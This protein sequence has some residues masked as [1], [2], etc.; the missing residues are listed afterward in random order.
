MTSIYQRMLGPEFGRLHPEI[1][2][3]FGFC[4][5]DRIASIGRGVMDR[6]WYGRAFTKPFLSL[7]AWR[8]IMFPQQG[9][10]VPFSIE[11]YAYKDRFGRETV[12]WIRKFHFPG[13]IRRFDATMIYSEQRR[14]IVDYLGTHQHL[15]VEIDMSPAEDGGIRLRSGNQYFYEGWIGFRFPMRFSGYA[16][17]CEWFDEQE[18]LFRIEV[19]VANPSFGPLFGYSGRFRA[20]YVHV[21]EGGVPADVFPLREERRE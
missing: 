11:N 8:N 9:E 16:D 5:E 12:T 13:R 10:N 7:G 21:E 1:R 4:S 18:G 6:V 15:A 17:V 2:R 20:E 19:N 14:K 3:R